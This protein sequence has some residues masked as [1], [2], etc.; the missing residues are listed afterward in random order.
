M[1]TWVFAFEIDEKILPSLDEKPVNSP[2]PV[3]INGRLS[4]STH[5]N[6][7]GTNARAPELQR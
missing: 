4:H 5:R 1:R 6:L 7:A 2:T 3:A